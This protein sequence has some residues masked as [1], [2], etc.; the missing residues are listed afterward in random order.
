MIEAENEKE[1]LLSIPT[2]IR[3]K[4]KAIEIIQFDPKEVQGW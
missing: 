3:N 1:A 2:V 4:G